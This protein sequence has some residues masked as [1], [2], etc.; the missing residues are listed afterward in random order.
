[1]EAR[2]NLLELFLTANGQTC[3][4]FEGSLDV[5]IAKALEKDLKKSLILGLQT[6]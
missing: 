6:V 3:A 2:A 1:M 4:G 5:S